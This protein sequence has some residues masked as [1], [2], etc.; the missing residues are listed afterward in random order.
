MEQLAAAKRGSGMTPNLA[1]A[2][3]PTTGPLPL[4]L[5][6][7]QEAGCSLEWCREVG[8]DGRS[9]RFARDIRQQLERI[10]GPDGSGFDVPAGRRRQP[11]EREQQRRQQ[12]GEQALAEVGGEREQRQGGGSGDGSGDGSRKRERGWEDGGRGRGGQNHQ[13]QRHDHHQQ[14]Q[15]HGSGKRR[16]SDAGGL[17]SL[18]C[19]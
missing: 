16:R 7:W 19:V 2:Q 13:R 1:A 11:D 8:V 5:Q 3:P 9:V 18:R 15:D 17:D 14:Q 10:I 6:A 4:P 12:G